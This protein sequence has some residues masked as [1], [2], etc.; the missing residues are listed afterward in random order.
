VK[1][2]KK[3]LLHEDERKKEYL[4]REDERKKEYLLR[5]DKENKTSDDLYICQSMIMMPD[6]QVDASSYPVNDVTQ[7]MMLS[8]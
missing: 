3:Y 5:E 6:D 2:R 4:L 8:R 7:L 1:I